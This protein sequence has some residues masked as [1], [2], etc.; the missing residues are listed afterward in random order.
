MAEATTI[1]MNDFV[2]EVD[3][4]M[5]NHEKLLS[6]QIKSDVY[7]SNDPQL[8]ADYESAV[9]QGNALKITIETTV[10]VWKAV[11][12]AWGS[13]T[14]VTSMYIGDVIDALKSFFGGGS[15]NGLGVIQIPAAA[16]VVGAI[17]AALLLNRLMTT[18]FVRIEATRIQR[19]NPGTS[20]AQALIQAKNVHETTLFGQ[21]PLPLIIAGVAIVAW[22]FLAKKK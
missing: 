15:N 6:S 16:F 10:G 21:S 8:I 22:L 9:S 17:A 2:R 7:N 14:D 3:K 20:R 4:F 11:K 19:D 5:Q 18:I 12:S 1:Q 13:V